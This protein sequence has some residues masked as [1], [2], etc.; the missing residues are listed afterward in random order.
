VDH[1]GHPVP[2]G[3]GVHFAL[4]TNNNTELLQSV[5]AVTTLGVA[6]ASF[7]I[8]NPGLLEIRATSDPAT[9]SVILQMEVSGE[10]LIVTVVAPT[11]VYGPTATPEVQLPPDSD[12][13]SP[14]ERGIP[15]VGGWL[16][17]VTLLV[18]TSLLVYVLGGFI[19][20]LRWRWR[21]VLCTAG[22]CVL[23]YLYLALRLPGAKSLVQNFHYG[24]ITSVVLLG[25]IAGCLAGYA[26][27]QASERKNDPRT[28]SPSD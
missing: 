22:G 20:S 13:T 26:W 16:I 6:R 4:S 7:N 23:A 5:D 2:D 12:D 10:G 14:I 1:N 8:S 27:R 25:A 17:M 28:K 21:W 18:G 11:P 9:I 15:G 24:G 19:T 3:T